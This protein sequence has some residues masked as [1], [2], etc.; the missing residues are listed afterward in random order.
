V[1]ELALVEQESR[2]HDADGDQETREKALLPPQV[3]GVEVLV[4]DASRRRFGAQGPL[5]I[6]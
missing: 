1:C 5:I 6:D 3:M 2:H 4:A